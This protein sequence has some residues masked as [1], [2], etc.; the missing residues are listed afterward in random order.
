MNGSFGGCLR[1]LR[2]QKGVGRGDFPGINMKEIARIER[3][4]IKKPHAATVKAIARKLGV[5][6]EEIEEY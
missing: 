6:P 1:R 5:E 2:L 3:G 4:E